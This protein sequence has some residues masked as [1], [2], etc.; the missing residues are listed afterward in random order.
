MKISVI[1]IIPFFKKIKFVNKFIR[2]F[3]QI[4]S[5]PDRA[6]YQSHDSLFFLEETRDINN[7]L[8]QI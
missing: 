2:K 6:L 5:F 4:S 1:T 3:M 8:I 7:A